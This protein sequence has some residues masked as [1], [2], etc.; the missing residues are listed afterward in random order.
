MEVAMSLYQLYKDRCRYDCRSWKD[1]LTQN[2]YIT[3]RPKMK[4][5]YEKKKITIKHLTPICK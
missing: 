1:I 3:K 4:P 5:Y 2:H